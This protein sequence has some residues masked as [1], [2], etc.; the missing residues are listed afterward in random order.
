M[1]LLKPKDVAE[2][3]AI[4]QATAYRLIA[5]GIIPAIRVCGG[6]RKGTWRVRRESLDRWMNTKERESASHLR[7]R[8]HYAD[9]AKTGLG[10]DQIVTRANGREQVLKIKG[11]NRTGHRTS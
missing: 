9:E 2:E 1:R 6:K 4:S 11:E 3:L 10:C 8:T 5:T 7:R